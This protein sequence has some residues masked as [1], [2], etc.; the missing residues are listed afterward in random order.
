M[1][2]MIHLFT[3]DAGCLEE[4]IPISILGTRREIGGIIDTTRGT[5]NRPDDVILPIKE[6]GKS[7]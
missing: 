4:G 2:L 3:I 1:L 5:E 6:S 7:L